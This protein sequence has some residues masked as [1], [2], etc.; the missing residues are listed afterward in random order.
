MQLGSRWAVG[1]QPPSRLSSEFI[2]AIQGVEQTLTEPAGLYWTLTW[3]E[4]RPVAE[5]DPTGPEGE[6]VVVKVNPATGE[7]EVKRIGPDEEWAQE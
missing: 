2:E 7:P 4:G 6:S 3:L 1:T 5:L